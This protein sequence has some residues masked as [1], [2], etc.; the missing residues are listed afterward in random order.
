MQQ[1]LCSYVGEQSLLSSHLSVYGGNY[2][3]LMLSKLGRYESF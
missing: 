3:L 1:G 2:R